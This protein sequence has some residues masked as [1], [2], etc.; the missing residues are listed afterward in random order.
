MYSVYNISSGF[1]VFVKSF[2]NKD[3]ARNYCLSHGNEDFDF[4]WLED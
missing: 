1:S 3:D 4:M 2:E